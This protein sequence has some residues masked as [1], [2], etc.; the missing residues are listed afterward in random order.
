MRM[1]KVGASVARLPLVPEGGT[2]L[3]GTLG[4]KGDAVGVLSA[5]LPDTV[6]MDCRLHTCHAVF[7]IDHHIVVLAY[8]MDK[9][10]TFIS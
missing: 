5:L 10:I 8:L 2:L 1:P 4:D 7:H 6:P 9:L 3:D